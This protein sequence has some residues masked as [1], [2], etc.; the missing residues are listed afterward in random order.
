MTIDLK[1]SHGTANY[2]LIIASLL[3]YTEFCVIL[4]MDCIY[5][6]NNSIL[7]SLT[8]VL[9]SCFLKQNMPQK[10]PRN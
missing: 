10:A 5:G 6:W 3:K 2:C 1:Y 9:L 4:P 7:F 8:K